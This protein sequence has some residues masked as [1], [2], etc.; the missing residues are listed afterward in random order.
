MKKL[1]STLALSAA[2]LF[3][4]ECTEVYGNGEVELKLATGSPGELGLVKVVA[5]EF[6]KEHDTKFCWIKAASAIPWYR[7]C[8]ST[9]KFSTKKAQPD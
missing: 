7:K 8:R 4:S 5:E 3:A 9:W 1:V 2:V 6:N